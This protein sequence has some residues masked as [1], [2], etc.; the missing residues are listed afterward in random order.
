[1]AEL[2]LKV[3]QVSVSYGAVQALDS[4]SL[5]VKEGEI[6][7][8]LGANGAGKSTLLKSVMR[9]VPLKQGVIS[10]RGENLSHSR[11]SGIVKKGMA[12][13]PEGRGI[14]GTMSVKENLEMGAFHRTDWESDL[15]HVLELFPILSER[16][17][18]HAGTLSGGEQQMLA[19]GR[20]IL[21]APRLL[22]LD[23][24]SLGLAPK[25]IQNIFKLIQKINSDG[26]SIL[27]IEQNA[28]MA[29]KVAHRAYVLETGHIVAS[30]LAH[31]IS[32]D[33]ELK[34]AY[35]GG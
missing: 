25:I 29:I 31:E 4:V 26:I 19:I 21:S 15:K 6:V 9:M 5:E 33:E 1:M 32:S 13:V 20:A 35:L 8:L 17:H 24:P 12:L 10:F 7:A 27:L 22:L 30:G 34:K 18:Q 2:L 23:E 3:E 16:L 28:H 14:L 11:T